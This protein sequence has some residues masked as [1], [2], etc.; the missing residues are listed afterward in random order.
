MD[1]LIR[2]PPSAIASGAT[3]GGLGPSCRRSE[4]RRPKGP[5]AAL[6]GPSVVAPA[7]A[8]LGVEQ[9]AITVGP[10]DEALAYP[11]RSDVLLLEFLDLHTES[12]GQGLDF[13]PVDPDVARLSGAAAAATGA[14]KL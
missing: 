12:V 5:R 8:G 7:L 11:H 4:I 10:L 13:G 1:G 6:T 3:L 2:D 14:R 9:N